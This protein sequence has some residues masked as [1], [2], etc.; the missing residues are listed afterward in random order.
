MQTIAHGA[1][2]IAIDK[3]TI[4]LNFS[5]RSRIRIC[6]AILRT[7]DALAAVLEVPRPAGMPKKPT[8]KQFDSEDWLNLYEDKLEETIWH[9]NPDRDGYRRDL[10]QYFIGYCFCEACDT[11]GAEFAAHVWEKVLAVRGRGA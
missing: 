8:L 11:T 2:T 9:I 1:D 4:S 3:G 5:D 6:N 10:I 7:L